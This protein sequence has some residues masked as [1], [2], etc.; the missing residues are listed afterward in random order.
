MTLYEFF[1]IKEISSIVT[2]YATDN[3][4]YIKILRIFQTAQR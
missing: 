4:N 2:R 3:V 1:M